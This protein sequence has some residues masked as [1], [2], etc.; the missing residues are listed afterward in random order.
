MSSPEITGFKNLIW[1]HY[2]S[3]GRNLPWREDITPYRIVV[4]EIMLQ[5]TQVSRVMEK[6]DPFLAVFPEWKSLASAEFS[7]VYK[8]WQGLGYNRRARA[9][10]D[11]ARAVVERHA[12]ILP[13]TVEGLS[14][15]PGIGPATARSIQAFAFNIP[16]VFIET[17]I[18]AVYIH[19]FFPGRTD[20]HDREL[21]PLVEATLHKTRPREWYWALMDYGSTL[22]RTV[23]NPSR[24]SAH[25]AVQ[26]RFEGSAREVRGAVLKLLSEEGKLT[27]PDFLKLS[28]F[29]ERRL[30]PQ[31]ERLVREGLVAK[32]GNRYA[33][34][35]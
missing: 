29:S 33:L 7:D 12:G 13:Q 1:K 21:L 8:H 15:L 9:L 19:H 4:S 23:K 35:A 34:S 11:T 3:A 5:Q 31:L 24:R 32:N 2:R 6:F 10:R 20:V 30:L 14:E 28:P 26:S 18:R 22:K 25:H 16:S 17:N 27:V